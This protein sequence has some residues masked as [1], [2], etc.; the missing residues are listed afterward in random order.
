MNDEKKQV[1]DSSA[2]NNVNNS[3]KVKLLAAIG[4]DGLLESMDLC[5]DMGNLI[6]DIAEI[7]LH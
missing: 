2:E 4:L 6:G 7:F 3:T 5:L 1:I